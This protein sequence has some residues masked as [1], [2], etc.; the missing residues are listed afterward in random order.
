MIRILLALLMLAA[1][2]AGPRAWAVSSPA[3]M[4]ADPVQEH[5]AEAI[6]DQLRCLVCQNESVEQSDADLAKD[7]RRIIRQ[8]VAAGETNQQVIAW[9]VARYGDFVRLRP[10]FEPMTLVLWFAPL[11]ALVVGGTAVVLARRRTPAGA[12]AAQRRRAPA[13]LGPALMFELWVGI[14]VLG[15]LCLLPLG[16]CLLRARATRG[17]REAA[18]ALHRAQLVELERELAEG[19]IGVREH[20][21]AVLEVQRRLLAAADMAETRTAASSRAGILAAL[22]MVPCAALL[23]YLVGGSPE[24]PAMPLKARMAA[25]E[26]RVHQEAELIDELKGVLKTLDPKTDKAREGFILLGNAEA[27]LGD[28][29]EAAQA[30]KTALDARFDPTLAVETAEAIS[31]ANGAVTPEAERLFKRALAEGDPRA[32]WRPMAEKRLQDVAPATQ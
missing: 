23:L 27:R 19:R 18:L 2:G 10:P 12:R 8:R 4:L 32:P 14:V 7:L 29:S 31:E 15:A 17:R 1:P 30:W 20:E 13:P 24:L 25:M 21:A 26:Q 5:R 16:L 28:M 22:V 3:E 6:G 11:I 9:M